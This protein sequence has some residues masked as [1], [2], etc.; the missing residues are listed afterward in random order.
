MQDKK[1][2]F[3]QLKASFILD[4]K[5]GGDRLPFYSRLE[6]FLNI[7]SIKIQLLKHIT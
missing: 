5:Q 4:M 7:F 1:Y 3:D 2:I 6:M